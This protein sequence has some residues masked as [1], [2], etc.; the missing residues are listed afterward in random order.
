MNVDD[1]SSLGTK[2]N[3]RNP[4]GGGTFS[5]DS[6]MNRAKEA[7]TKKDGAAET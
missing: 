4:F 1:R 5:C 2:V 6:T 3:Y 7:E